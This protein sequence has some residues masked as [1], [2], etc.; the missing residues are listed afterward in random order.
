[1][2]KVSDIHDAIVSALSAELPS[3]ARI[4]NPYAIDENTALFLKRSFG[5]SID[6][7]VNTQRFVGCIA[8]WARTYTVKLITQVVNT[9]N[10]VLGRANVEKDIDNDRDKVFKAFESTYATLGGTVLKAII[11]D[12]SGIQYIEGQ[13]GKF[14][15]IEMSLEVEY[16]ESTP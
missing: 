9:E 6:A 5:V 11:T 8:T 13:Q 7:G 4:P 3:Y 10:D 14:L 1:M 15:A 2:S 12:D 16:Q